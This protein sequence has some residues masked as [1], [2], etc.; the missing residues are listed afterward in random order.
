MLFAMHRSS[1]FRVDGLVG[2]RY[3]RLA[4]DL[5]LSYTLG[6]VNDPALGGTFSGTA[7]DEFATTNAFIGGQLG[8]RMSWR[9][10]R[11]FVNSSLKVALGS[12]QQTL[13]IGEA[14]TFVGTFDVRTF[15]VIVSVSSRTVGNTA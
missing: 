13:F 3:C 1:S 5:N 11:W 6:T 9:Q 12:N 14:G 15:P 7:Q 10:E 4:E 8:L 2:V